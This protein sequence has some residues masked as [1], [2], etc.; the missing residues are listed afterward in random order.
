MS[1][2]RSRRL[3]TSRLVR[4]AGTTQSSSSVR[5]AAHLK[6]GAPPSVPIVRIREQP[7]ADGEAADRG[8]QVHLE[9]EQAEGRA[10]LGGQ[11]MLVARA[12][13]NRAWLVMLY[14]TSAIRSQLTISAS[15][16]GPM[17]ATDIVGAASAS[18]TPCRGIRRSTG[19][20][21]TARCWPPPSRSGFADAAFVKK[22][23]LRDPLARLLG[24]WGWWFWRGDVKYRRNVADNGL[25]NCGWL[26]SE[27]RRR[28]KI[29]KA[30]PARPRTGRVDVQFRPSPPGVDRRGEGGVRSTSGF[31]APPP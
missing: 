10:Y 4:Q 12:A 28:R 7:L 27:A 16:R 19:C 15:R 20:S 29:D 13:L 3:R 22:Q 18:C 31:V 14:A 23:N 11:I 8:Q 2:A 1:A 6:P 5:M 30:P 25:G 26:P 21:R 9:D 24:C 17:G